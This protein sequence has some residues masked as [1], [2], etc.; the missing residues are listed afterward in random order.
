MSITFN[1]V[2][3]SGNIVLPKSG[4]QGMTINGFNSPAL[5][6]GYTGYAAMQSVAYGN[7]TFVA[8]GADLASS[9]QAYQASSTDGSTWTNP[10]SFGSARQAIMGSVAYGNGKFLAMGYDWQ[11]YQSA[12]YSTSSDGVTWTSLQNLSPTSSIWNGIFANVQVTFANGNFVAAAK[13]N[14]GVGTVSWKSSDGINWSSTYSMSTPS[15]DYFPVGI[16]ANNSIY[17]CVCTTPGGENCVLTSTDGTSWTNRGAISKPT[18]IVLRSVTYGSGKFV[19]V[20]YDTSNPSLS[21]YSTSSDGVTWSTLA[22]MS[23]TTASMKAVSYHNGLFVAVGSRA[24]STSTDGST[25]TTP[26]TLNGYSDLSSLVYGGG[27]FVA[28]GPG[29]TGQQ[30]VFAVSN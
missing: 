14:S 15:T 19:A 5:M 25:W 4:P 30:P 28:V 22:V 23:N 3:L 24:Y 27:V 9:L 12:V 10:R 17:V 2:I 6:N 20:G 21:Y 18:P 16:T 8:V 11:G 13:I 29:G 1:G 26:V 7:G